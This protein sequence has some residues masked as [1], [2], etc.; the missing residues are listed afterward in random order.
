MFIMAKSKFKKPNK[1]LV[2]D[3]D[4]IIGKKVHK[5]SP[6]RFILPALIA[7]VILG[8]AGLLY[9]KDVAAGKCKGKA[10]SPL[11][12]RASSAMK[13]PRAVELE[14]TVNEILAQKNY[15][16]DVNCL[17]PVVAYYIY[18]DDIKNVDKHY[19]DLK[20]ISS[21]EQIFAKTYASSDF[22]NLTKLDTRI[23]ELR[24]TIEDRGG[25][26]FDATFY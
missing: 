11:Y 9:A 5:K 20:K 16:S 17:M 8:I 25:F 7:V 14:Y 18:M 23:A 13:N 6:L 1:A 12:D 10:S 26:Q 21:R 4:N 2:V 24:K 22:P 3:P 19:P 15:K